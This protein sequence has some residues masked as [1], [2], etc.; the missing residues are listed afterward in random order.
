MTSRLL[1]IVVKDVKVVR[2][3]KENEII[4]GLCYE[5]V[6]IFTANLFHPSTDLLTHQFEIRQKVILTG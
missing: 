3:G 1:E 5:Y 4:N 2:R 6:N